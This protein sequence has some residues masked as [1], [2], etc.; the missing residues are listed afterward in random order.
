MPDL[1]PIPSPGV[2][3]Y[4]G[5]VGDPV[6]IVVHDWYG[7]LPSIEPYATALATHG[8]RVVV[9]DFYAGVCT[10]DAGDAERLMQGLDV[11]ESLALLED[12]VQESRDQGS[13]KAAVVGFSMGGWLALLHA[14]AGSADAVV[15]YYASLGPNDHGV[16]PCPVQLHFAEVDEWGDGDDP[17]SFVDRLKDHGTPVELFTYLGTQHSF[18]NASIPDRVDTRAA[19]LAFART[20][21]FLEKHLV[22]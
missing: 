10:V 18:A 11:G 2:P 1:V 3:L 13:A 21:T 14:Q 4:Y 5:T 8:L 12:I 9:P 20:A 19:A 16:I 22:D 15:A 7:R 17:E 6:V